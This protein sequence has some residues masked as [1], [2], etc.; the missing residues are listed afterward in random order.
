MKAG[1]RKSHKNRTP[2]ANAGPASGLG[3]SRPM[4]ILLAHEDADLR[5]HLAAQLRDAGYV[6]CEAAD[7]RTAHATLRKRDPDIIICNWLLPG[8]GGGGFCRSLREQESGRRCYLMVLSNSTAGSDITEGLEAGA[9]DFVTFP[10]SGP[11]LLGRLAVGKRIMQSEADLRATNDALRKAL[12]KLTEAQAAMDRD[13]REAR[14]LQQGLVKQRLG[15]FGPMQ[16]SL[17]LRPAGHIGGDLVGFFPIGKDRVGIYALDVS[18]HGVA[19]ALLTT[20]L[21]VHLSGSADHNVALRAAQTGTEAVSPA[22]LAHFFNNMMLEEMATDTYF[23]MVYAELNHITGRLR[24]VQAGHPHPV[25]QRADGSVHPLGRGGMPIGVLERPVFDEIDL[26]LEPGDRLL[27]CSDGI[28][29]ATSPSGRQLGHDGIEA[30]LRTNAFL[31]GNVFLESMAWSV[32][33]YCRG[34]RQDDMSAV[35]VEYLAPAQAIPL[36]GP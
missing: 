25:L 30:I 1:I 26:V 12:D 2:A 17:L 19:A 14:K 34:D 7:T 21:S 3:G 28:T 27:I 23:T 6:V 22:S 9:D 36:P 11:K 8:T 24:M 4:E 32:S 15:R 33:E 5:A 31:S 13:M 20:Q 29:E 16:M 35:L 10:I 18:G